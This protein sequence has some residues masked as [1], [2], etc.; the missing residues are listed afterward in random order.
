MVCQLYNCPNLIRFCRLLTQTPPAAASGALFFRL[1]SQTHHC[2]FSNISTGE[3]VVIP[4]AQLAV[5]HQT[6]PEANTNCSVSPSFHPAA[7]WL[8]PNNLS[9]IHLRS[10]N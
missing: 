2:L 5:F 4:Q 3:R 7:W 1:L 6:E 9:I 10:G 8:T